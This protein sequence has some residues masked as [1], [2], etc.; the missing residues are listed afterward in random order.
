MPTSMRRQLRAFCRSNEFPGGFMSFVQRRRFLWVLLLIGMALIVIVANATTLARLQF[1]QLVEHSSAIARVRCLRADTR[2]ENGEIWTDTVFA[3]VQHAKGFLPSPIVVRMPGGKFQ[4][5]NSHIDGVP[6]FRPGEEVYVFL[7]GQPGRQFHIVGWSQGTFRIPQRFPYG[8]RDRHARLRRSASVR[9]GDEQVYKIG[10]ESPAYRSVFG[11]VE[12]GDSSAGAI[13]ATLSNQDTTGERDTQACD[14]AA[15]GARKTKGMRDTVRKLTATTIALFYSLWSVVA[16][17]GYSFNQ[18][19]PDV[20]QPLSA[21]G[22]SACPIAAHQLAAPGSIVVRWSTAFGTNP[23]TILTNDQ[24][25]AGR[26]NEIEQV[27]QQSLGVWTNVAG[28]SLT[29]SSLAPLTRVTAAN[30][31]GSDGLNSICFDQPDMAFTPGVLAF[32]RVITADAIGIQVGSGAPSTTVG[33]ILDADIYF[34]PSDS[35]VTFA[36]PAALSANPKSYDLESLLAHE[37][38]HFLGFSHSAVWSA[39]M[40]PFAPTPGTFTGARPTAQKLDAPL[41]DDDRTGLRVLYS[42][43]NDTVYVGSIQGRIVPANPLSL[44]MTP[45]G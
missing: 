27:I 25:P 45:P 35:T 31:C 23:Q 3:V 9:S 26:L 14:G 44:P 21:S 15:Q 8:H 10:N 16:A 36:T 20:R 7:T 12:H 24:T 17:H 30:S 42:D 43:P 39:M 40:F 28:S 19:V 29:P 33:Q 41:A 18:I 5:L 6:E 13:V 32:T 4:H 38:G 22:G 11:K 37:L 1:Y 2:M 34:N